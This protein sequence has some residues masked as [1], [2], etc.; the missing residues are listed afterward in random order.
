MDYTQSRTL[1]EVLSSHMIQYIAV[2]IIVQNE[3]KVQNKEKCITMLQRL[4]SNLVCTQQSTHITNKQKHRV[5]NIK[6]VI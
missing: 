1:H 2:Y 5:I 4:D 6:F 3:M